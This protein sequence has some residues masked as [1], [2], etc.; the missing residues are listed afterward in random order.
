MKHT[1]RA[2][3]PHF[4]VRRPKQKAKA[5]SRTAEALAAK[6]NESP[7]ATRYEN[8]WLAAAAEGGN[9]TGRLLKFVKGEWLAGDDVLKDGTE[10]VA[11]IDQL[12]RGWVKFEDGKVVDRNHL[13]KVADGFKPPSR[14]ELGDTD[15]K[16]WAEKD[17]DNRPRDPW[18]LQ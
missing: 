6:R 3:P 5:M 18:S 1:G 9:E 13:G 15:P 2:T 7:P 14:E 12:I 17:A 16:K 11:H 8:P 4:F 10:F